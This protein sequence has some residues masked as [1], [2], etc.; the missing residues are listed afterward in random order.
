MLIGSDDKE[1]LNEAKSKFI[2][3]K[4]VKPKSS[5]KESKEMYL[6]AMNK[7]W[8]YYLFDDICMQC[9]I[10]VLRCSIHMIHNYL[11]LYQSEKTDRKW[12]ITFNYIYVIEYGISLSNLFW[13]E[14]VVFVHVCV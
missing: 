8:Y 4:F 5:R 12:L 6:L 11:T 7:R 9:L 14:V 3:A 10:Q 13:H 2:N 1:L